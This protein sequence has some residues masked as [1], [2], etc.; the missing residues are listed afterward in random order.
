MRMT[1]PQQNTGVNECVCVCVCVCVP[2]RQPMYDSREAVPL[3]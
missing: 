3:S 2:N 1:C